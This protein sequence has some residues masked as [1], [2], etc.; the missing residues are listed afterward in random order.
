MKYFWLVINCIELYFFLGIDTEGIFSLKFWIL[1]GL[2]EGGGVPPD[3]SICLHHI[4]H[5]LLLS[6]CSVSYAS[7]CMEAFIQKF[8]TFSSYSKKE[9]GSQ[10]SSI[11]QPLYSEI[12]MGALHAESSGMERNKCGWGGTWVLER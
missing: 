3:S 10:V 6:H 5:Q 2:L 4:A 11:L 1:G 8:S 9:F 12:S 7:Q